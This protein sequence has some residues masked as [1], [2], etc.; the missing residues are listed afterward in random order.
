MLDGFDKAV[1]F[2]EITGHNVLHK[3]IG[4]A[5]LLGRSFGEPGFETRVEIHF[6]TLQDTENSDCGQQL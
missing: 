4:L 3:F 6:H 1:F 5:P 2:L